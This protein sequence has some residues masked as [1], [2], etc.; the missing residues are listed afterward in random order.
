MAPKE[1]KSTISENDTDILKDGYMK[2]LHETPREILL[3]L[4]L[5]TSCTGWSA[6]DVKTKELIAC[7]RLKG[8]E[9][10]MSKMTYPEKPLKKMK[11]MSKAIHDVVYCFQPRIIFIEEVNLGK[12][13]HSQKTL[14]GLHWFVVDMLLS[15]FP[16][17]P[18][19][20]MDS[21]G[22]EG[23]RGALEHRLSDADKEYNKQ[24]RDFNKKVKKDQQKEVLTKKHVTARWVNKTFKKTFDIDKNATDN[25]VTDAIGLGFAA[26]LTLNS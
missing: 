15:Q 5:S 6:F 24:I 18:M 4:D 19:R 10:G 16:E 21:D 7:G 3:A 12:N 1:E 26:T 22:R 8:T 17:V 20:F 13:R 9:A 25:D 2:K 23:W 11:L 14:D